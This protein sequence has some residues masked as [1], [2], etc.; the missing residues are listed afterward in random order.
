MPRRCAVA[1]TIAVTSYLDALSGL[2]CTSGC[3]FFA[4]SCAI[5]CS[6]SARPGTNSPLTNTRLVGSMSM[7]S[8]SGST[9]GGGGLPVGMFRLTESS[10][11]G[12]VMISITRSTSITSMSGVVLMSIMTSGSAPG[13]PTVIAMW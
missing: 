9:S 7:R 6:S 2:M 4:A 8:T 5:R 1:S 10:W 11:M 12:I 13:R 3:G